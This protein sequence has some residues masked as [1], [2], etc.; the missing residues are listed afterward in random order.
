MCTIQD[1]T[2]LMNLSLFNNVVFNYY[3]DQNNLTTNPLASPD[4]PL[5]QINFEY[6]D[7]FDFVKNVKP[8]LMEETKHN[9]ICFNIRSIQD[10]WAN[11]KDL[12]LINGYCPFNVI[13]ITETWFSEI[14]DTNEFSL[15]GFQAI[16]T[17]RKLSKSSGGISLYIRSS[18]KFTTLLDCESL[19][20]QPINNRCTY[21][22][23]VDMSVDKNSFIFS[24]FYKPLSFP[25]PFFFNLFDDFSS[26]INLP[27]KKAIVFGDFN[28]NLLNV[29]NNND[30]D[31]FFETLTSSG[32]LP[33]VLFPTRVDPVRS[34]AT[35]IDNIFV[36]TSLG[37]H[38]Y[39][40]II[41][42]DLSDHFPIYIS[43]PFL[44]AAQPSRTNTPTSNRIY[45]TVNMNR[46]ANRLKSFDWSKVLDCQDQC[47]AKYFFFLLKY[48]YQGLREIFT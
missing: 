29:S 8:K 37:N 35:V 40:K 30:C 45:N 33:T 4:S 14:D 36:S 26:F 2:F 21:S 25:T 19:F 11:F 9:V 39:S 46:F 42:S 23:I 41:F 22:I 44:L 18:L 31:T 12:I 7:T 15:P 24:L 13:G 17:E 32:L 28:C 5:N 10:K 38:L 47:C 16:H 1:F 20:S 3:D 6:L 27:Q 48:K 43:L 34:R